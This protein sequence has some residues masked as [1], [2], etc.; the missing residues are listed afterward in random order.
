VLLARSG[1]RKAYRTHKLNTH[2]ESDQSI[3]WHMASLS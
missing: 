3:R 1:D 2:E